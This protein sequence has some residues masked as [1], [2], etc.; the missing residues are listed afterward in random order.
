VTPACVKHLAK[1]K[2]LRTIEIYTN[3]VTDDLI[4]AL[5]AHKLLHVWRQASKWTADR[6]TSPA[7]VQQLHLDGTKITPAGIKE[8]ADFKGLTFIRGAAID[9]A[10][11]RAL[12]EMKLLHAFWL[13]DEGANWDRRPRTAADVTGFSL[14]H[15]NT[16]TPAGLKEL[17][18]F[19]H[20]KYLDLAEV[21]ITPAVL[22]AVSAFKSLERLSL[23]PSAGDAGL[24][25]LVA[26]PHLHTLWFQ[27]GG[28]TDAGLKV[29][30]R[31]KSLRDLQLQGANITA[32]GLKH[33]AELP[34]TSLDVPPGVLTDEALQFLRA[35][36]LLHVL[37]GAHGKGG[38]PASFDGIVYL[39]L[40]NAPITDKSVKHLIQMKSLTGVD[41][42]GTRVSEQG[43]AELKAARPKMR[44]RR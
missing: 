28:V 8:F 25:A 43:F 40:A 29:I 10:T 16:V 12:G 36:N 27:R 18:V 17:A 26:L 20:L 3:N 31:I 41:L 14:R 44:I 22:Q 37:A 2:A 33:I 7:D 42:R 21:P 23:N 15:R 24:E 30:G 6:P 5:R 9:D 34:L 19:T 32:A 13:A 38:R 11:L 1:L 35:K 4:R 39:S